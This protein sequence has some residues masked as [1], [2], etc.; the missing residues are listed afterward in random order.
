MTIRRRERGFTL[1]ELLVVIAIIALLISMLLPGL[2][3]ARRAARVLQCSANLQQ[4]GV[5]TQSYAADFEDRIWAFNWNKGSIGRPGGKAD[6]QMHNWGPDTQDLIGATTDNLVW[7]ARQAT[8]IVRTRGDR[9]I[10]DYPVPGG[11]IPHPYYTHLVLND[12]LAQRLPEP[13]V[14]CPED[15][16]RAMWASNPRAFDAGQFNPMPSVNSRRWPY[17]SSYN[18]TVS[19]YEASPPHARMWTSSHGSAAGVWADARFGNRKLGD[20]ASPSNKVHQFD[21]NQRH[22]GRTQPFFGMVNHRQPLLFFDGSASVRSNAEGNRGWNRSSQGSFQLGIVTHP[23]AF[24]WFGY[25]P[26]PHEPRAISGGTDLGW[27]FYRWTASG[28]KG[29]DFGGRELQDTTGRVQ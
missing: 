22:F 15:R 14:I 16:N 28:L 27:G 8:W 17:S 18:P 3:E 5:A 9:T 12:Y 19:A 4:Y 25:T 1:I 21:L 6:M 23:G 13:M 20:I 7:A 10:S 24:G 29:Y 26:Q 2:G 11:W